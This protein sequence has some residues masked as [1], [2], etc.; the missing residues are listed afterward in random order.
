MVSRTIVLL[1]LLA[2]AFPVVA[3]QLTE[4][5]GT[6]GAIL[7]L[8]RP[9]QRQRFERDFGPDQFTAF[10]APGL[11]GGGSKVYVVLAEVLSHVENDEDLRRVLD[12]HS[13]AGHD[14]KIDIVREPGR[15]RAVRAFDLSAN[16]MELAFHCEVLAA[17]GLAYHVMAWSLKSQRAILT[18]RM[19]EFRDGLAFPDAD[20]AWQRG[21]APTRE[22]LVIGSA[23]IGFAV[24][25]SVL[26]SAAPLPDRVATYQTGDENLAFSIFEL[27]GVSSL[28]DVVGLE[29]R[30]LKEWDA[31]YVEQQRGERVIG[32]ATCAWLRGHKSDRAIQSLLL[33]AGDQ[34]W[35]L[36]RF[37]SI[38][39]ASEPRPERDALFDSITWGA[40][41]KVL[42]LPEIGDEASAAPDTRLARFLRGGRQLVADSAQWSV[43]ARRAGD[44]WL[45]WNWQS[46]SL[47]G[48]SSS[49]ALLTGAEGIRFALSWRGGYLVGRNDGKVHGLV[50]EALG[51]PLF[52]AAAA[53]T[54]GDDLLLARAGPV[55]PTGFV[56]LAPSC[57]L[58]RRSAAGVE[59]TL[60]RL[61]AGRVLDM[62][63]AAPRSEALVILQR[64]SLAGAVESATLL[65]VDLAAGVAVE[66]GAWDALTAVAT[67]PGGWVVT[68][69]PRH[70]PAGV[71]CVRS[72][73]DMEP[74]ITGEDVRGVE[75]S[76]EH[77][78]CWS[79]GSRPGL[80]ELG[81]EACRS[82]GKNCQPF[83][84]QHLDLVGRELFAEPGLAAPRSEAEVLAMQ[85]RV[86]AIAQRLRGASLSTTASD[87]DA[88]LADVAIDGGPGHEGRVVLALLVAATA[89]AGGAR[90]VE[91]GPTAWHDWHQ[92]RAA[93]HRNAF[94]WSCNPAS[95]VAMVLDD[96]ETFPD[97]EDWLQ[98]A[99]GRVWLL[100]VDAEALQKAAVSMVPEG[101]AAAVEAADVDRLAAMCQQCEGNL[102]LR[103][104]VYALLA[105]NGQMVAVET[106]AQPWTTR[107]PVHA[108]DLVAWIAARVQQSKDPQA[109]RAVFDDA[110]QAVRQAPRDAA[111][112][113]WLGRAAEA[114]FP[115]QSA[116]ARQCYERV[117]ALQQWG[118]V[119]D[120]AKLALAGLKP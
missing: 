120:A 115:E 117:L 49:K 9:W 106:L 36:V 79:M 109:A 83:A 81:L 31:A 17:D 74:W 77:L 105:R 20:S 24:R 14:A 118:D 11:F 27:T 88:L 92:R 16:G 69:R 38:G 72:A 51:E 53:Q 7:E 89:I 111:L 4:P 90:W 8:D 98:Q 65:R 5:V 91:G 41:E 82:V 85:R 35:V 114:A 61:P 71:F 103:E 1:A 47:A 73:S 39:T 104:R 95:F 87:V 10:D 59:T 66:F 116:R 19:D 84:A 93:P 86:D 32:G 44:A 13:T 37:V 94:A 55:A 56:P 12:D 108:V 48:P 15:R 43:G 29:A 113:L 67:S 57:T 76:A 26:R 50:D 3:Q 54:F 42:D 99:N 22:S 34:R 100:G 33:P 63:V 64:E 102:A 62:A 30:T 23:R 21:L 2:S 60:L 6:Q 68:G 96:S 58:V 78:V 52:E 110:M 97:C 28:A 112:S 107:V 46:V 18:K 101:F 80:L 45:L 75:A 70:G 25:P 119:A 40:V